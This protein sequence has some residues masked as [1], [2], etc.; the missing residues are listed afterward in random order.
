MGDLITKFLMARLKDF[1]TPELI[2]KLKLD[3]IC[4][5]KAL[6]KKSD[7]SIDDQLV[8][9]VASVLGVDPADCSDELVAA[10]EAEMA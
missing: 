4:W 7:N 6:A 9:I 2:E 8:L 1:L 10:A 5:L 3:A